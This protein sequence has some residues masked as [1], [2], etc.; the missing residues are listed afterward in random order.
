MDYTGDRATMQTKL[1]LITEV[2]K[3][4]KKC[5]INNAA[6]LLNVPNLKECFTLLKRGKATGIDGVSVEEYEQELAKNL[7]SLVERMKQQAYK[8]L[9][10]RRTYLEKANGKLRPLGIPAVEDK[11]VQTGIAR[12][13]NAIYEVDFLDCSYGFRP[14]RSAHQALERL[15]KIIMT[16]PINHIIDADIKGF[17]DNVSHQWLMKF[18]E[19]RISDP[20][21]LRLIARFLKNG[22]MEEGT[23]FATEK[24][25]PQGGIISPILAN[26]YLHYVLDLWFE[27]RMKKQCK[28]LAELVRYAD[29]F[30]ICVELKED[31]EH[32][33]EQL[34]LR[35]ESFNLELS[36]EKTRLIE[37][38]RHAEENAKQQGRKPDSFTFLGFT[39]YVGKS[40]KGNFLLG[41]KTDRHKLRAK[42]L[43][44]K[45]WFIEIKNK[46]HMREWWNT[47]RAK[48]I[49]HYRYYGISGNTRSL[50]AFFR[51]IRNMT[52]KWLNRR[53]H[54][55]SFSWESF[56]TY[57]Q[58][59]SL[60]LPQ[61]Y[62]NFYTNF[63]L[64]M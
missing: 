31:A 12:I 14:K 46:L 9:P 47:L 28:G 4:G 42:L 59:Y 11:L 36:S 50:N 23:L 17:F 41:R 22:Y 2:A 21:L 39:H 38:G 44:M 53:S 7:E 37:F 56:K 45:L 20:N 6:Y 10:V 48:L 30:V 61:V 25:T 27:Y 24:G 19:Y 52:Y 58:R 26:L 16:K 63:G 64:P 60:P 13:L 5:K 8:P 32:I 40:R 62:H 55:Q 51:I 18:L 15:D 54:M 35:L 33:Y 29:D 49:G 34:R 43:E 57:L 3:R 1:N